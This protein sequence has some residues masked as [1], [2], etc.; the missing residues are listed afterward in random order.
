MAEITITFRHD[1]FSAPI[2]NSKRSKLGKRE[3]TGGPT[4]DLAD[5]PEN[6]LWELLQGAVKDFLQVGLKNL[7]QDQCTQ[8]ECLSAMNA[9]LT[10][11]KSGA[12]AASSTGRKPP[13]RDPVKA[14]AR[15]KLRKAIQKRSP[16]ELDRSE[17]TV[18]VNDLFK[19][20]KEWQKTKDVEL[21]PFAAL[22]EDA[23]A[24]ARSEIEQQSKIEAAL[25]VIAAKAKK[26]GKVSSETASPKATAPGKKPNQGQKAPAR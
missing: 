13:A 5:I 14:A 15:V 4:V 20:H 10:L 26:S 22:V 2:A 7:D 8:A 3:I 11:L 16:E 23:L 17:L 21:E 18:M 25:G 6:V 24:Q 12:M 1:K 19:Q 9:R